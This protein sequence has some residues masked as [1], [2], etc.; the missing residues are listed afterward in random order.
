MGTG[1]LRFRVICEVAFWEFA[2]LSV[3]VTLRVTDPLAVD[4]PVIVPVVAPSVSPVGRLL[5]DHV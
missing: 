5:I 3:T 4:V 2:L 1:E